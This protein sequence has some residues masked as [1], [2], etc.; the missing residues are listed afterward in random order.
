MEDM[1]ESKKRAGATLQYFEKVFG[2]I[3]HVMDVTNDQDVVNKMVNYMKN[4]ALT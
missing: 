2:G 3:G 1:D 4:S